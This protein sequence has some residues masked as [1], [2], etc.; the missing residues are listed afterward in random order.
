MVSGWG[1]AKLGVYIRSGRN[2]PR[3]NEGKGSSYTILQG[4]NVKRKGDDDFTIAASLIS[5][6]NPN[7]LLL[8][9]TGFVFFA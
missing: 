6:I 7:K 5:C 9:V 3:L 1:S 8:A 4:K 2:I